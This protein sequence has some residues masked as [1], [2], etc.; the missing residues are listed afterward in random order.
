MRKGFLAITVC[1]LIVATVGYVPET[2]AMPSADFGDRT[3]TAEQGSSFIQELT[4]Q[5]TDTNYRNLKIYFEMP[6]GV[7]CLD[8]PKK[9]GLDEGKEWTFTVT[10]HVA[11]SLN[12]GTYLVYARGE[13]EE[14]QKSSM[15]LETYPVYARGKWEK[16]RKDIEGWE[17]SEGELT[18]FT[19]NVTE[20]SGTGG[21]GE[22]GTAFS[23]SD[24][25]VLGGIGV[26][27][28]VVAV[29]V[30]YYMKNIRGSGFPTPSGT[31]PEVG[32]G[33][34]EAVMKKHCRHCG[35]E[36]SLGSEFC[37]SCGKKIGE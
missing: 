10:F 21:E 18:K 4:L 5:G 2:R 31:V 19:L 36:N 33:Q 29:G 25:M 3:V 8:T 11:S 6:D 16:H 12:S 13:W 15:N 22:S 37:Y 24:P 35:A 30:F 20:K 26:V 17:G 34:P 14:Y 23:L 27:A 1:L 9:G 28:V 32:T 7:T